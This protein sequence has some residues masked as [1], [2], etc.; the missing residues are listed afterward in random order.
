MR[1]KPITRCW[2]KDN[3]PS[4]SDRTR[5]QL[6]PRRRTSILYAAAISAAV[7]MSLA[8]A[9]LA[10][11]APNISSGNATGT[12]G[13][14]F[15][16][17]ITAN[18]AIPSGGWGATGLPPGLTGP[19]NTGLISGTPTTAGPYTVHL[20]ANNSNGTGAKDVTFTINPPPPPTITSSGTASATWGTAFS[21]QITATNGPILSYGTTVSVPGVSFNGTTGLFSGTPTA[22]GTFSGSITATNANG[23]G[24]RT[25]TVTINRQTHTAP[26]SVATISPAVVWEG[27]TVTLDGTQSHTNPDDGSPL[28]YQW[29]QQAPN[30]PALALSPDNKSVVATFVAPTVPLAALNQP[31]SYKLKV[32]DDLVSGG[33]KNVMS[34]A[35]TT[36]VLASPSADAEPKNAHVNEG[37]VVMLNGGATRVQPGASLSYTWTAPNG[38][39][40]SNIHAQNPTFTAPLVGPAGQTLTFTLIVTEQVAGLAHTQDSAPDSV[41]INVD[42]VNQPPTAYASAD[43]N[44]IVD[45]AEVD[46]NT[47]GVTLYGSGS[48]PDADPIT[49]HWNQV[50]DTTGAPLQQGDTAV[51]LSS[52][53]STTP[54]FTAPDVTTAQQHI[55]LVFQLK[56]N[57]GYMDSGPSYVTIRV[58][59]TNDP[60]VSNPTVSPLSA[61]EG[62]LVTLDGTLS[63][64]PNNDPLTFTW[65]QTGGT[66]VTLSNANAV[67]PTFTA[68][69]VSTQQGSI[70]LT[71]NLTV[72]DGEFTDTKPVSITASHRN[73]PP[74][75]DAGQT[76]TFAEGATAFLDGSNS[77]DPEGDTLTFLWQQLDG[78]PVGLAPETPDNKQMSFVAP[79]VGVGGGVLHFKLTVT[80]SHG[81]SNSATVEVD[82]TYVNH[83]PTA[84]AGDEQ[85]VDEGATVSLSG[86]GT[87]PDNNLLLFSWSQSS[88]PSVTI[89]PDQADS[90]K[91][92]FIAPQTFCAGDVIVMTLTVDDQYGGVTTDDVTINVANVN[93]PPTAKGG[94]NQQVSEGASVELHGIG[95]DADME[96]VA[97]LA[98]QWTQTSGPDLGPIPSGKDLIFTAPS[99]GGGDPNASVDLGFRLTV[100]DSCNGSATDDITVHVAN[101]PHSP[102]AVAQGP[103]QANEGGDNVTLDGSGSSDP[104]NDPLTYTWT[105]CGGPAVTLSYASGDTGHT[106]PMFTTPWVSADT[107]LKFKLTVSDGYDGTSTAYVTV[108][109]INW[110][111][112]PN[113]TNARADVP[114]LWPPDHKMLPVQILGVVMRSD[115]RITIDKVTQDE[116]TNGLGDGDTPMD[117]TIHH[118]AAPDNDDVNLRAER[119]GKG[120]GR[121][122]KV[123][124]TVADPE[125]SATGSVQVVVPKSKKTDAAIDSGG[126]YDSTH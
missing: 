101:I 93:H 15:S 38:I 13:V 66:S 73:L 121:V 42:N 125:Q 23:T 85:T 17:Q 123:Y 61:L 14:S 32:T 96:E 76:E 89:I 87:D 116:P 110:H 31:V 57:D 4:R 29:Q 112:P 64:D 102:V 119:S 50:H 69:I 105:Q 49:F 39:T 19:S 25:L 104:D 20:T 67:M 100:S 72:D 33:D 6:V 65:A 24:S 55:D 40:L 75:A 111:T 44:S 30:S 60:P 83:P 54:T 43:P 41:T 94:G 97:G 36:T 118:N 80:D 84:E 27:D 48:D 71:F 22:V 92:T 45:M 26:T 34:N 12:V 7:A 47:A 91:A 2:R 5:T 106:M 117:A 62:D 46:E 9:A 70:T 68:P 63:S 3:R 77:Y 52:N 58:N 120:D 51:I 1:T 126:M 95:E 35:V 74:V 81:A 10:A 79:D 82:V 122:Y 107:P 103:A 56:T 115:D 28:T 113:V 59:N 11:S 88:G 99:I 124:F 53:T 21:Y 37:T 109:V 16:Y 78:P 8:T 18:Q 86:S 108:T 90:S 114:V 98:F